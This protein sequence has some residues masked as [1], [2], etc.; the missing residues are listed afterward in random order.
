MH[1]SAR[2]GGVLALTETGETLVPAFPVCAKVGAMGAHAA[3]R[4]FLFGTEL[5][6]ERLATSAVGESALGL[7]ACDHG[8]DAL[9]LVFA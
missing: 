7:D 8:L 5:C 4:T 9:G 6:A 2:R 3:S 1:T